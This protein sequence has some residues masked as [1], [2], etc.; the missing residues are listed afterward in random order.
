MRRWHIGRAGIAGVGAM[1]LVALVGGQPAAASIRVAMP[2]AGVP[3]ARDVNGDGLADMTIV[4]ARGSARRPS[5]HPYVVMGRRA[6]GAVRLDR[7]GS[8]G[9]AIRGLGPQPEV[10]LIGDMNGDGLADVAAASE[11]WRRS[12]YVWVIWGRRRVT[13]VDVRKLG[14][15]GVR[16]KVGSNGAGWVAPAGDVNGDGLA[17]LISWGVVFGSPTMHSGTVPA[18][19]RYRVDI[20]ADALAGAGDVNRDGLGDLIGGAEGYGGCPEGDWCYGR[21]W[22]LW[23]HAAPWQVD[24]KTIASRGGVICAP[25]PLGDGF[26]RAVIST[27]DVDGDGRP[28]SA[29]LNEAASG[30]VVLDVAPFACRP[31][32]QA[33]DQPEQSFDP[34]AAAWQIDAESVAGV[35]DINGDGRA[36]IVTSIMTFPSGGRCCTYIRRAYLRYGEARGSFPANPGPPRSAAVGRKY[37]TTG[38]RREITDLYAIGDANGDGRPDLLVETG[39]YDPRHRVTTATRYDIVTT[40]DDTTPVNLARPDQRVTAIH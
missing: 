14:S 33:W 18:A 26:G 8:G 11:T 28:D 10:A 32:P 40:S 30:V 20:G 36:D 22:A 17:D 19:Q 4:T 12:V 1:G 27:G 24:E 13:S 21:A 3:V 35:G 25:R 7:L 9:F 6:P 29:V 15:R 5:L 16:L 23:G 39:S 38:A 2:G 37:L 31:D 34:G